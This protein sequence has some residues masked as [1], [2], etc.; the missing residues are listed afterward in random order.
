MGWFKKKS[1]ENI[2]ELPEL[3]SLPEIPRIEQRNPASE[4]SYEKPVPLPELEIKPLSNQ[5]QIHKIEKKAGMQKSIYSAPS[6]TQNYNDAISE[7]SEIPKKTYEE[8]P[9]YTKKTGQIYIRLDQFETTQEVFQDIKNKIN[10]IEQLLIKTK[11]IKTRE[12]KE[13][14]EW[15][16]EIQSIKARIDSIDKNIFGKLD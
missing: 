3:P 14:E 13:L 7:I 9:S 12:E 1:E 16:R 4:F 11:E 15:E 8:K 5:N 6:E 2:P 10:E